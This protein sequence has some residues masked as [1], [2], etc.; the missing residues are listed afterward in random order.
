M[1]NALRALTNYK[2]SINETENSDDKSGEDTR[3]SDDLKSTSSDNE[4][5]SHQ[6][7]EL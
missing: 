1:E 7:D 6:S 3:D 5:Q 2:A 4:K